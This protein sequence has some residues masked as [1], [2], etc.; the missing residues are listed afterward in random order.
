MCAFQNLIGWQSLV[1]AL[2]GI[3]LANAVDIDRPPPTQRTVTNLRVAET[4]LT[5]LV[6]AI[7]TA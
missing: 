7:V 4:L 6:L 1:V 3:V 2:I 5:N